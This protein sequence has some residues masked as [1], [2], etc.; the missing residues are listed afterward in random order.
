MI[1][2]TAA[3]M[4]LDIQN[5]IAK[6]INSVLLYRKHNWLDNIAQDERSNDLF[7]IISMRLT[8]KSFLV[9]LRHSTRVS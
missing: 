8:L 2:N 7:T 4:I 5:I 3:D 1:A 9:L 6:G